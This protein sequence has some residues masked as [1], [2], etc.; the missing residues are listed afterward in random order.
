VTFL[1][2]H[3]QRKAKILYYYRSRHLNTESP[4]AFPGLIDAL[5]RPVSLQAHIPCQAGC[6]G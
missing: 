3:D 2:M 6:A 5:A 1:S 4:E